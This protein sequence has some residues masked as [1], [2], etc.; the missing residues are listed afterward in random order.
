[1]KGVFFQQGLQIENCIVGFT[2]RLVASATSATGSAGRRL[3]G[4]G[5]G[6]V[7]RI[8]PAVTLQAESSSRNQLLNRSAT[9]GALAG[10]GIGKLLAQFKLVV[11][12]R[13]FVLVHGHGV[14]TPSSFW[15][16]CFNIIILGAV[17]QC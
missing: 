12:V 5:L 7:T 14:S 3:G 6:A 15:M 11:T 2:K 8:E 4:L 16:L 17:C 9:L 1:M 10:G 13:T